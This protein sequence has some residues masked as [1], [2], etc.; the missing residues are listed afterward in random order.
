M[1]SARLACFLLIGVTLV[2]PASL[3]AET[4]AIFRIGFS[5]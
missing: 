5:C 3:H 2:V 4:H 1:K